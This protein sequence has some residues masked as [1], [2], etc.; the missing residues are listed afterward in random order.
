MT[1]AELA[2]MVAKKTGTDLEKAKSAV[3]AMI[4]AISE[5]IISGE[6]IYLRGFGTF[7]R[8]KRA[9]KKGR[10]IKEGKQVDIPEHFVP[11]FKPGKK[12]K[13]RLR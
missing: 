6:S 5:T 3:E 12:F 2:A 10:L 7:S 13:I 4:E 1:K 11:N 9:A 8:K